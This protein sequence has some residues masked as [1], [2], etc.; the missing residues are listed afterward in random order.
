MQPVEG[1]Y[2]GFE[3]EIG[4]IRGRLAFHRA[5]LAHVLLERAGQRANAALGDCLREE[6][7][8][9]A[10]GSLEQRAFDDA[11]RE[12]WADL[13]QGLPALQPNVEPICAASAC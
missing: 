5:R 2:M 11:A 13:P 1:Q 10:E 6:R 4:I 12:P 9:F 3:M 8:Q 7:G